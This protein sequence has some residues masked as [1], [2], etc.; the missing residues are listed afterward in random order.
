MHI[1]KWLPLDGDT[2]MTQ[3][4]F[5]LNVFGY[6]HPKGR[7]FSFLKYIPS[8]FK[9]LFN[10]RLLERTWRYG[11]IELFRA[12]KLY[13]AKNYKKFLEVFKENFPDYVYFCPFR[14]KEIISTPITHVK[15]VFVPRE[16]LQALLKTKCRDKLQNLTLNFIALVSEAS[17]VPLDDFGVH[18]SIA[19]N[20]HSEESDIDIVIYGGEN[21]RKVESAIN[22]L[23]KDGVLSY[24]FNNRIDAA[25]R[26]KGRYMDRIFMYT[27]VRKPEEIDVKYGEHDYHPI[28]PVKFKCKVNDDSQSMFRPATYGIENYS[29]SDQRSEL[30]KDMIPQRVVSM[31]GC[32]RN[33]ARKG[34]EIR[35]SGMLER[36]ENT[37]TG[38]T[39]YQ[40][41]VGS[42]VNEEEYIWP[43]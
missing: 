9:D 18:G 30:P 27:A 32:Y 11:G 36:V 1:K 2:I 17:G 43:T 26:F 40:V 33:V 31:I 22:T 21:F 5:L 13:T 19:L 14:K 39:F 34:E 12:E 29:P 41:V 4:G 24:V 38:D 20:M 25:R 15:E 16:C 42:A 3:E 8:T 7:V 37:K 10:I 23:V 28:A 6:E 35:V